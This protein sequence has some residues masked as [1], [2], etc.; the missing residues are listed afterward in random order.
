MNENRA[1]WMVL[2]AV[3]A[4]VLVGSGL[5]L[6]Y[7]WFKPAPVIETAKPSETQ[8]DG[9]T[10]IE[11][12]PDAKAKPKH[13]TPKGAKVERVGTIIAQ[14]ET[15]PEIKACTSIPCPSVTI[16]TSL[17]RLPD[18]SKRVIV[19]SPDGQIQR[20]VDIPVETAAPPPEPPKWAAGLSYSTM[21]TPGLWV[22]RDLGRVRL[23]AEINQTRQTVG[24][25]TGFE[26][27]ARIGWAF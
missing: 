14:G 1:L 12:K 22:E 10:V 25:P 23:G 5:A 4:A 8:A 24:G 26:A 15:P 17:V 2:V 13:Q 7:F 16:E 3:I 6:G 9:S 11:R 20:A 19:S 18:G 21:Q 27:R